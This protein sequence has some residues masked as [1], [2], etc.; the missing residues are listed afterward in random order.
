MFP[1]ARAG[2]RRCLTV[3]FNAAA[4]VLAVALP[5]RGVGLDRRRPWAVAA[6]RP[7]LV[8]LIAFGVYTSWRSPAAAGTIRMPFDGLL[9][10]WALLGPGGRQADRRGRA[11]E[12]CRCAGRGGRPLLAAMALRRSQLFGWGGP[13]DVHEPDL[14]GVDRSVDCGAPRRGVPPDDHAC[15]TTG[16]GRATSPLPNGDRHRRHRL[17][18]RRRRRAVRCTCIDDIPDSGAGI[19]SG[20]DRVPEHGRWPTRSR[21]ESE[22]VI[23]LGD[24]ARRAA[25]RSPGRI[26]LRLSGAGAPRRAQL[27]HRRRDL[28]PPRP[29]A[30][31]RR[32]ASPAPGERAL[33]VA[34]SGL[35]V[36]RE[37]RP[38]DRGILRG[39]RERGAPFVAVRRGRLGRAEVRRELVARHARI[40][41]DAGVAELDRPR[42]ERPPPRGR[43]GCPRASGPAPRR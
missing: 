15:R 9:A 5:R 32:D 18:R 25:V 2:L 12:A 41:R 6:V 13:F 33:A 34:G 42:R 21:R 43:R 37:A 11:S 8:L 22:G 27:A 28:R 26:E 39:I 36:R 20:L 23:P 19:H 10:V 16:P 24:R 14:A 30:P 4:A 31:R 7:L 1:P 35:L 3:T 38:L 40:V 29:L 17:D